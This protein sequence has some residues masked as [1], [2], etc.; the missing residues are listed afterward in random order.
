MTEQ[1]CKLVPVTDVSCINFNEVD[2]CGIDCEY[3]NPDDDSVSPELE[4][5][6]E[7]EIKKNKNPQDVNIKLSGL[8]KFDKTHEFV[9]LKKHV[10]AIQSVSLKKIILKYKRKLNDTDK[11]KDGIYVFTDKDDK[12][13][14]PHAVFTKFDRDA[15]AKKVVALVKEAGLRE[16]E[17]V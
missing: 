13:L 11:I 2:G 6:I 15:R 1:P 12:L 10:F 7:K 9:V 8:P 14:E 16:E 3:F 5:L 17:K 4:E